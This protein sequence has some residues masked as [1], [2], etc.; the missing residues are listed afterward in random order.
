MSDVGTGTPS[1]L[2]IQRDKLQTAEKKAAVLA[3]SIAVTDKDT[4]EA[5]A[6]WWFKAAK[7]AR[8]LDTLAAKLVYSDLDPPVIGYGATL[9]AQGIARR[10]AERAAIYKA[11]GM[12]NEKFAT[13]QSLSP[14]PASSIPSFSLYKLNSWFKKNAPPE[15]DGPIHVLN[16]VTG[17]YMPSALDSG[18]LG[19]A[20]PFDPGTLGSP[21][22][23]TDDGAPWNVVTDSIPGDSPAMKVGFLALLAGGIYAVSRAAR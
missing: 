15:S 20:R 9:T 19:N 16:P 3:E 5:A 17:E 2:V 7:Y 18:G 6:S 13:L 23:P 8:A 10:G 4:A 22:E 14:E 1:W 12:L 21:V 11:N